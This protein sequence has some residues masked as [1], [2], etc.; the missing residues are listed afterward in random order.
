MFE[1]APLVCET[2]AIVKDIESWFSAF[3]AGIDSG[4]SNKPPNPIST[5]NSLA[6]NVALDNGPKPS[7]PTCCAKRYAVP[8]WSKI[9]IAASDF[10]L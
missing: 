8:T 7:E 3:C 4:S 6:P 9:G 5:I 2:I 10:A 1:I